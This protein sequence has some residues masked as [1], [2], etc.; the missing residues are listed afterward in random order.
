M[1][2]APTSTPGLDRGAFLRRAAA[3][4]AAPTLLASTP[5][6]PRPIAATGA[7][8]GTTTTGRCRPTTWPAT[9]EAARGPRGLA[10]RWRG[11]LAGGVTGAPLVADRGGRR[12]ARRRGRRAST[13]TT[14]ASA[15]AWPSR[16]RSTAPA[17]N[18][19]ARLLRRRRGGARPRAGGVGPRALP[20]A[21]RRRDALGG[22]AAA[23]RRRRRLL[24][25]PAGGRRG[26]RARRVGRRQRG[27]RHPR[28]GVGVRPARRRAGLE[29]PDACPRAA[30]AA[31]CWPRSAS[32]CGGAGPS[33]AT[34]SPYVPQAADVPGDQ[35]AGGARPRATARCASSTRCTPATCS[36]STSTRRRCSPA[37]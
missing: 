4:A 1:T 25:G 31:A 37:A 2:L 34:G 15:G 35:R 11:P 10:V 21:A 33:P 13:S 36:A 8:G 22:R 18:G 27:H 3:L 7:P 12:L 20:A 9:R 14:G 32:T 17:P 28:A 19:R 26:T 24:L 23:R 30:T 16:R 5:R 29:H 6:W